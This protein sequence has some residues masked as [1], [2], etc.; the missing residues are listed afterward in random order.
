MSEHDIK[1]KR[2]GGT[3]LVLDLLRTGRRLTNLDLLRISY[4]RRGKGLVVN[5]RISDAREIAEREGWTI[6]CRYVAEGEYEYWREELVPAS[7]VTADTWREVM[8][9][10]AA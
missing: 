1:Q 8:E 2:L 10:A 6:R 5:S 9:G 7:T 3:R 4:E